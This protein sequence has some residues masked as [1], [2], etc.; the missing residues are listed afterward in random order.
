MPLSLNFAPRMPLVTEAALV[1]TV[2]CGAVASETLHRVHDNGIVMR[3]AD[4][5]NVM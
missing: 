4:H 5:V 3:R 2:Q 1:C